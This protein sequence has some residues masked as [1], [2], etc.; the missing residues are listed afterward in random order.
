MGFELDYSSAD[1]RMELPVMSSMSAMV[2]TEKK[3]LG[4]ILRDLRPWWVVMVMASPL[5]VQ[6]TS[7]SSRHTFQSVSSR[8]KC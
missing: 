7:A 1:M 8:P 5:V 3:L 4:V 6:L 2:Q